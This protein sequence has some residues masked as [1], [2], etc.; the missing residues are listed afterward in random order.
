MACPAVPYRQRLRPVSVP[1]QPLRRQSLLL[2]AASDCAPPHDGQD[3]LLQ[4]GREGGRE[5]GEGEEGGREE[6]RGRREGGGRRGG[7]GGEGGGRRGGGGREERK[8]EMGKEEG[9]HM[10]IAHVHVPV[11]S[12]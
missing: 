1:C 6:E 3:Y 8:G 11:R 4:G 7:G 12:P 9:E 5:G 10:Y 2:S